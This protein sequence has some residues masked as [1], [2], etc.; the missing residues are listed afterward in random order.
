M[1]G[2]LVEQ[3]AFLGMVREEQLGLA[4]PLALPPAEADEEGHGP[5]RRG[6]ARGLRVEA[7]ERGPGHR[8]AGQCGQS[9]AVDRDRDGRSLDADM[10]PK[11]RGHDLAAD[12]GR[13]SFRE[14][15]TRVLARGEGIADLARTDP[16][17]PESG[18]SSR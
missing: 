9:L 2:D 7:D 13:Q 14:L 16:R 5:G 11:G 8:L 3:G 15:A 4:E 6:E 18:Q 1:A 17:R 12:R 10:Q